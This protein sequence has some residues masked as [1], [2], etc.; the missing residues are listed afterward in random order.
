MKCQSS[1]QFGFTSGVTPGIASVLI[2][3]ATVEAYDRGEPWYM[4]TL[5]AK[6]AFDTVNYDSLLR[7]IYL[8]GIDEN[9]IGQCTITCPQRLNGMEG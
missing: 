1:L 6:K 2:T 5:D 3:E 9:L 8:L 7:K 4:C